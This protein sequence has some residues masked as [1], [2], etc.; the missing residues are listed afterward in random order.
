MQNRQ[1]KASNSTPND[2]KAP[3]DRE[4]LNRFLSDLERYV[5]WKSSKEHDPDELSREEVVDLFLND[6]P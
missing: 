3:V 2:T 5:Q 6:R 1:V 4:K